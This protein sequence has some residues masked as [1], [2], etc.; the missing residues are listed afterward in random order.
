VQRHGSKRREQCSGPGPTSVPTVSNMIIR[1]ATAEDWA[2]IYP[3]FPA[4]VATGTTYAYPESLS[5]KAARP[6][7]MEQ[8]PGRTVVAAEGDTI[9]GSAKMARTVPAAVRTW[10]PPASW[11]TRPR[12][13]GA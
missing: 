12:P 2:G 10:P 7:W 3:F 9:L 6:V 11:S 8:S 5:L 4:I 13:G 1:E